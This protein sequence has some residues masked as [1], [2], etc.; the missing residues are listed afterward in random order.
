M[1]EQRLPRRRWCWISTTC[2][3][4]QQDTRMRRVQ[5]FHSVNWRKLC[6]DSFIHY[7]CRKSLKLWALFTFRINFIHSQI[8]LKN[9]S[10]F[11]FFS[12]LNLMVSR[13]GC[14]AHLIVLYCIF[15]CINN[16]L[17]DVHLYTVKCCVHY[18]VSFVCLVCF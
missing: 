5:S 11:G 7:S 6:K 14:Y 8:K 12:P 16:V 13:S 3:E 1:N 18:I 17:Y 2:T 9:L 10:V 15:Y 4:Q